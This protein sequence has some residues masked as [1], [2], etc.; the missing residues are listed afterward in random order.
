MA[1]IST[2]LLKEGMELEAPVK[3]QHGQVLFGPGMVLKEKHIDMM[4]AW[5]IGEAQVKMDDQTQDEEAQK[6]KD[7]IRRIEES[8]KPRFVR[9]DT[10]D[11]IVRDIIRYCAE[12]R[13][14][15][16]NRNR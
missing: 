8:I 10:T 11:P 5:G 12:R 15:K 7:L 14:E 4:M 6:L 13:A 9:C 3:N 16:M 2:D 1:L